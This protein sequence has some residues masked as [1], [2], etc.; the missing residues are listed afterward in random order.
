MFDSAPRKLRRYQR[1]W[2]L[3][4][5]TGYLSI[6]VPSEDLIKRYIQAIKKEKTMDARDKH[7]GVL[8]F[9]WFGT[10]LNVRFTPYKPLGFLEDIPTE[11]DSNDNT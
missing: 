3:V 10:Q 4:K 1:Y 7:S 2:E 6:E 8:S 11:I 5:R 9:S